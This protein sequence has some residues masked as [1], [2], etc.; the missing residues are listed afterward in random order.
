MFLLSFCARST[1]PAFH[2]AE[3]NASWGFSRIAPRLFRGADDDNLSV[4]LPLIFA[5]LKVSPTR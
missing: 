5:S 1:C 2:T 4:A 3:Q